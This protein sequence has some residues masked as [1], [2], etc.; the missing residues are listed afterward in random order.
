MARRADQEAARL[1]LL[2]S[3]LLVGC[4]RGQTPP[5]PQRAPQI[6]PTPIEGAFAVDKIVDPRLRSLFGKLGRGAQD[7]AQAAAMTELAAIGRPALPVLIWS[8][9]DDWYRSLSM[10]LLGRIAGADA[11]AAVQL[12]PLL[13]DA[14]PAR[15]RAGA[16]ILDL[17]GRNAEGLV[18]P[19]LALLA[20]P[21]PHVRRA[22]RRTLDG[23][24]R[25][26]P[27]GALRK[28]ITA[29]LGR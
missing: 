7:K 1:I 28:K 3:L 12:R 9:D 13:S 26:T 2:A 19:L 4:D 23:V 18:D 27:D 29:A 6:R 24:A 5:P 21:D 14:K 20:D 10:E 25:Q 8:L 22:A 11:G 17:A 15:R 16:L